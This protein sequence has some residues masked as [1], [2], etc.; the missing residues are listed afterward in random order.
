M[1]T[2]AKLTSADFFGERRKM[3]A[4]NLFKVAVKAVGKG[5]YSEVQLVGPDAEE[6][7]PKSQTLSAQ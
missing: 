2:K 7:D 4:D 6:M 3:L 5:F 1:S